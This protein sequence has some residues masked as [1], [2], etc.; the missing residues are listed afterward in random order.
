MVR[1]L[2]LVALLLPYAVWLCVAYRYHLLDDVNLC[3]HEAG[4]LVFRPLGTTLHML[5][6]TLLQLAFPLA[7]VLRF[8]LRG[9]RYEAAVCGVWASESLMYTARYLG[10]A[11][12]QEL[13][14]VGGHVHD[15]HWILTRLDL[16]GSCDTIAR[17]L[18]GV[19]AS[20]L[21]ASLFAATWAAL[22]WRGR[23]APVLG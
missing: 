8:W 10:D 16:L 14:L 20:G 5:G 22:A 21:A 3:V 2:L 6:G 19:A 11:Q 15:W 1:R 18:H 9:E 13:P 17:V 4:H 23:G 12:R 7:F